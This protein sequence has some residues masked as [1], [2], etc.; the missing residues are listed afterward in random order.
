[1]VN[2]F[3][4][5]VFMVFMSNMSMS[6]APLMTSNEKL[7]LGLHATIC[8]KYGHHHS[9]ELRSSYSLRIY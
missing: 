5:Q 1:M 2:D 8:R 9:Q 6:I 4:Y 7:L 3:K